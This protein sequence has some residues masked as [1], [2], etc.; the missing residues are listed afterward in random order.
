[1]ECAAPC[2]LPLSPHCTYANYGFLFQI[3]SNFPLTACFKMQCEIAFTEP[4]RPSQFC[5]VCCHNISLLSSCIGCLDVITAEPQRSEWH[6]AVALVVLWIF[7]TFWFVKHRI[8][9]VKSYW[10]WRSVWLITLSEH[11]LVAVN[12]FLRAA[13]ICYQLN[14]GADM[15]RKCSRMM[16]AVGNPFALPSVRICLAETITRQNAI[17]PSLCNDHSCGVFNIAVSRHLA[18]GFWTAG[19]AG[20]VDNF[21]AKGWSLISSLLWCMATEWDPWPYRTKA[22]FLS[23]E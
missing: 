4:S 6:A 1:M 22:P 19:V 20:I 9:W 14:S 13:D 12:G 11:L 7:V 15:A 16:Y 5:W 10:L 21:I 2:L 8:L 17:F 18:W 3:M 23:L